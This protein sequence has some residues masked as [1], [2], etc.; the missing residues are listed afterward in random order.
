M[1]LS[2]PPQALLHVP[3]Q[4][5]SPT[6]GKGAVA[7]SITLQRVL[8]R[9]VTEVRQTSHS[10]VLRAHDTWGRVPLH[11]LI[12]VKIPGTRGRGRVFSQPHLGWFSAG[13][14]QFEEACATD[15]HA[16][17]RAHPS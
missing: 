4:S 1:G 7:A 15:S 14:R 6:R 2:S 3:P 9:E 8:P 5:G 17:T 13:V 10:V 12:H 16:V 11:L